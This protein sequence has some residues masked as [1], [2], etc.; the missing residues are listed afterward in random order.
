MSYRRSF[1]MLAVAA[2]VSLAAAL[3]HAAAPAV[4]PPAVPSDLEVPAGNTPFL[5]GHARGTQNYVCLPDGDRFSW[6]LFGPQATLFDDGG[7]QQI[8]HF[9][10]AN[11]VE[12][13][14]LRATWQHSGDTSGVWAALIKSSTDPNFV[15]PDAIA[16]FLLQAK[17]AQYGPT[18]GHKLT[19]TTYVQRVNT[20]GGLP[21]AG[22]CTAATDVGRKTLVPYTADY[23][24]YRP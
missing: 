16:W 19:Y 11:P 4:V 5:I 7:N 24:F 13:G 1:S 2:L 20:A 6:T 21:P 14:T 8:T 23:V 10:S 18:L 12:N 9:L 22:G 17:G 3:A 15:A